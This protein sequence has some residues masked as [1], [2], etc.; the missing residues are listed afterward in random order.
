MRVMLQNLLAT[1]FQLA[2]HREPRSTS[3]YQLVVAK[4]GPRLPP[5]KAG[6][7]PRYAATENLPRVV[8][9]G[10]FF[11]NTS[12]PA[13]AQQLSHLAPIGLPVLDRTGI[14]GVYDITLNSAA[15]AML[16]PDGPSLFTLIQEQL[17]LRLVAAKEVIPILIID[18]AEEPSGN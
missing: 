12:L 13:F 6:Q 11:A 7:L 8:N 4:G 18:H 10:F 17:G 2:V 5:N 3:V 1:R 9:G 16:Q 15:R 14:Q